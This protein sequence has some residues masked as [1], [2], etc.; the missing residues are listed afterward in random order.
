MAEP[1]KRGVLTRVADVDPRVPPRHTNALSWTLLTPKIQGNRA[2]E[3]M[4]T[5]IGPGGGAEMATHPVEHAY[6]VISGRARARVEGQEF[7]LGPG[8]CL[9]M[10]AEAAHDLE[11]VGDEPLQF[12]VLFAPARQ[13]A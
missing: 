6:Y 7:E 11:V 5:E 4:L 10:D 3:L 2:V 9:Y 13:P 1:A 12:L 8:S